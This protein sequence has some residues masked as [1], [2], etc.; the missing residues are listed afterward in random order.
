MT[1]QPKRGLSDRVAVEKECPDCK[2]WISSQGFINHLTKTHGYEDEEQIGHIAETAP[3]RPVG[4]EI[5]ATPIQDKTGPPAPNLD[6]EKTLGPTGQ[7]KISDE[8]VGGDGRNLRALE[9]R[10]Y[11]EMA[12]KLEVEL[13]IAPGI[14]NKDQKVGAY[15]VNRFRD[16]PETYGDNSSELY[17]L[18]T[19]VSKCKPDVVSEIVTSVY[20]VRTE[21][22]LEGKRA[23][24][25]MPHTD[26]RN[27][28]YDYPQSYGQNQP[29]PGYVVV[30]DQF[31]QQHTV[32]AN[33]NPGGSQMMPNY[34]QPFAQ[35][36]DS[37]LKKMFDESN[38]KFEAYQ[39][40]SDRKSD[41]LQRQHKEEM[42]SLESERKEERE[43]NER[44]KKDA[45]T[46]T[47]IDKMSDAMIGLKDT[48]QDTILKMKE[49]TRSSIGGLA[50]E[51]E[52]QMDSTK[53]GIRELVDQIKDRD[54]KTE[55]ETI[56]RQH[57]DDLRT[58]E[59][60][61]DK[62]FQDIKD[63]MQKANNNPPKSLVEQMQEVKVFQ[64]TVGG[65]AS[66][67]GF[68]K[69]SGKKGD[70]LG[71]AVVKAVETA[72]KLVDAAISGGDNALVRSPPV[73]EFHAI[74]Q[75]KV[76]MLKDNARRQ[77]EA[78]DKSMQQEIDSLESEKTRLK[79]EQSNLIHVAQVKIDQ[80]NAL[81]KA[82]KLAIEKKAIPPLGTGLPVVEEKS[83]DIKPVKAVETLKKV[84]Q[85]KKKPK[86]IEK[87][88]IKPLSEKKTPSKK[89]PEKK[90]PSK[91]P[92]K[93]IEV[94]KV[95]KIIPK[96]KITP[97]KSIKET[98]KIE[99]PIKHE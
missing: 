72:E 58:Q 7:P 50:G 62:R 52:R 35:N 24:R 97:P 38:Q 56:D 9:E 6:E 77:K 82:E 83:E 66:D 11:E 13:D 89:T 49:E 16:N 26:P 18:I 99:G 33:N 69:S 57:R 34:N 43:K 79:M 92:E 76:E 90:T 94:K 8:V 98:K 19:S 36:N 87:V 32:P 47:K 30:F 10:M 84:E 91:K 61:N 70:L 88:T 80:E 51:H 14:G 59:N 60:K 53:D 23:I 4:G 68:S 75:D 40:E 54:H 27:P 17:R 64:E 15:V 21:Y 28:I 22:N 86:V 39:K 2:E 20:R 85:P 74:N 93:K 65:I 46:N 67:M 95:K 29:P 78:R 5:K 37:E 55:K 12:N 81:K 31:G 25:M 48:F 45:E 42:D 44:D 1:C 96:I 73:G 3:R 41:E 71:N 63:E